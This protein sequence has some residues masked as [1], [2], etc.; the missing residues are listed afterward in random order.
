MAEKLKF[1]IF[2]NAS[3]MSGVSIMILTLFYYLGVSKES[4]A[5][6]II[7]LSIMLFVFSTIIS[8]LSI[9]NNN[10]DYLEKI[11]DGLFIVGLIC[12]LIISLFLSFVLF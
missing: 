11:A 1:H 7:T 12:L 9:R 3:Q 2:S 6:E 8:Y 4:W 5:D 10:L